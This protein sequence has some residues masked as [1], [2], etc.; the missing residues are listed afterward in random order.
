MIEEVYFCA[1]DTHPV[2]QLEELTASIRCS[3]VAAVFPKP[4]ADFVLTRVVNQF[5]HL[6]LGPTLPKA[7][8]YVV[9]KTELARETRKLL[10]SVQRVLP[11]VEILPDRA[12][13]LDPIRLWSEREQLFVGRGRKRFDDVGIDE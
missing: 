7:F 8:D 11:A 10:H 5:A 3:Q 4:N 1:D 6:A 13:R 2:T 12:T 9:F